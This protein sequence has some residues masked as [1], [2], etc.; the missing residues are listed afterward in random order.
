MVVKA[1]AQ[2]VPSSV[3]LVLSLSTYQTA[4]DAAKDEVRR[5]KVEVRSMKAAKKAKA[6]GCGPRTPFNIP[7]S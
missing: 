5:M 1:V 6:E 2:D 3:P 7:G 4:A